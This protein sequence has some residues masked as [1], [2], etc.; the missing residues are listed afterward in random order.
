[1]PGPNIIIVGHFRVQPEDAATFAEI[2]RPHVA[3]VAANKRGCI[4]YDFAVDI[5]DPALFRNMECW[6]DQQ[7]LDD[8]LASEDF[9]ITLGEVMSRVRI[10]EQAT[11]LYE[12]ATQKP[13]VVGG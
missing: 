8:H 2:L 6:T 12:I 5:N 11:Q 1:M 4:Y 3:E 13:L 7:A 9:A 10:V